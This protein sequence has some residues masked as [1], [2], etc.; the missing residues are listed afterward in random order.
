VRADGGIEVVDVGLVMAGVV[1]FHCFGVEVRFEG[2]VGVAQGREGVGH[3]RRV[4]LK[5]LGV[6]IL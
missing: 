1:D 5:S 4:V 2:G 3:L 6:F